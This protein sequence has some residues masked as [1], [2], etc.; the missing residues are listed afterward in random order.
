MGMSD[1][2]SVTPESE[3]ESISVPHRAIDDFGVT[4]LDTA[5]MYGK[6]QNEKL[7]GRALSRRRTT[8]L[9]RRP[10]RIPT[11]D[12]ASTNPRRLCRKAL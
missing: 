7:V 2:Y 10:T 3:A 12:K 9:S 4:L 11:P 5:D 1:F 8:A 6:G